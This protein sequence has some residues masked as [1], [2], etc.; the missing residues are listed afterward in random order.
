VDRRAPADTVAADSAA[1]GQARGKPAVRNPAE[2]AAPQAVVGPVARSEEEAEGALEPRAA[3]AC[4]TPA[5]SRRCS[6]QPPERL[7]PPLPRMQGAL[8]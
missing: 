8:A 7:E 4:R 3:P 1:A 5:E 2:A 6:A